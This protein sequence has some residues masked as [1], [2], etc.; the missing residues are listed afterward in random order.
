MGSALGVTYS[1][2]GPERVRRSSMKKENGIS[3]KMGL[4]IEIQMEL[5]GMGAKPDAIH[6]HPFVF[7]P[8]IDNVLG[9]HVTRKEEFVVVLKGID[10]CFKGSRN[11]RYFPCFTA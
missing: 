10:S 4:H 5:V 2:M 8:D 11:C 3:G 9:E 1:Q 6:L 7:D